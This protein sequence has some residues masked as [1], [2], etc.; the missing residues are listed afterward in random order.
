MSRISKA[1]YSA[2][3]SYSR[4]LEQL[5]GILKK[6]L[7]RISRLGKLPLK[8]KSVSV[9]II[10]RM[11]G[12]Y[13]SQHAVKKLLGKRYIGAASDV[14]V[15]TVLFYLQAL[16]FSHKLGLE[17]HSEKQIKPKK[18]AL[19]PDISIW[20]GDRVVAVIEC[21]TQLGWNRDSWET[22]YLKR[23][24]ALR[25]AFPYAQ[26]FLLVMTPTNWRGFGRSKKVGRE[27][28]VLSKEWPDKVKQDS[29]ERS[30]ITP[31]EKLFKRIVELI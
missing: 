8:G 7:I 30:V 5:P 2:E 20:K 28:F 27:Y 11:R 22:D 6:N 16:N 3:K 10:L 31:I 21:K 17:V 9:A 4:S 15:E 13:L 29:I 12:Y 24:K 14:F 23:K 19:R 25:K 1:I 26:S 18:K